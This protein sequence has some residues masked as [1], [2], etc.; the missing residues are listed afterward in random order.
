MFNLRILNHSKKH[1]PLP[2]YFLL[3]DDHG[4]VLIALTFQM[5]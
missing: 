5:P 2:V 1:E 4:N 3:K